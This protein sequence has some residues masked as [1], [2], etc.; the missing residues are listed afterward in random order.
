M[1]SLLTAIRS[2]NKDAARVL[3][4][5]DFRT[6]AD[7]ETL[8]RQDLNEL[9]PGVEKLKLRKQI[10]ATV[11]KHEPIDE[12]FR[13][14][15]KIIPDEYLEAAR[16]NHGVLV[17]YL[18]NLK[19]LKTQM[20]VLQRSLDDQINLLEKFGNSLTHQESGTGASTSASSAQVK[21]GNG[22]ID[23][24]TQ[25]ALDTDDAEET[26][27]STSGIMSLS[28]NNFSLGSMYKT[29]TYSKPV[30][31]EVKYKTVV[32]GKTFGADQAFM[33]KLK[34]QLHGVQLTESGAGYQI[35]FLFCPISS[36]IGSDV[37]A[38]MADVR[39][40]KPVILVLMHHSQEPKFTTS[41]K[42]WDLDSQI[43]NII[44]HVSVFYHEMEP[45]LLKCQEND[46]A[47][48]CIQNKILEFCPGGRANTSGQC[49]MAVENERRR[50]GNTTDADNAMDIS[51]GS[52]YGVPQEKTD[53]FPML[54]PQE[55]KYKTVVS[56]KT[57]GADQAFM[58]KLKAKP[59]GVQLTESGA[60]HQ[61]TFLFCPI[62]SRIGSDVQ[63]AVA[64]V[65]DDKP[66]ILVLMHH[67]REA[68]VTPSMRT[69]SQY[70]DHTKILLHVSVFYHE[71]EPG[72]LK[73]QQNDVAAVSQIHEK[74]GEL[75][76]PICKVVSGQSKRAKT[77]DEVSGK[78]NG[79]DR[80]T[81]WRFFDRWSKSSK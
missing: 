1:S 42:T 52:A 80:N 78:D 30:L 48:S 50:A 12:L 6:D 79:P 11:Q 20:V 43:T 21:K 14:A 64:E 71:T 63:A 53:T 41:V 16:T 7:I 39:D 31:L 5:A 32:R 74:L 54:T 72:L 65:R 56:G 8:T 51:T 73:C 62:S 29:L 45:G 33:G 77:D 25:G 15:K 55:V 28:Y 70:V 69:W 49:N 68:K 58:D 57:F 19:D 10:F 76:P 34:D 9:F 27:S 24:H 18:R 2:F 22:P 60:G 46:T 26:P 4:K 75:F 59:Q 44:L 3:E 23:D 35:T 66:I 61:I 13:E 36:R 47:V 81:G 17:H 40:D 37:Q 67:S 38:A